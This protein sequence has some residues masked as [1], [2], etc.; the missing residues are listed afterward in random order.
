[1]A[2]LFISD[3]H[4]S[5]ARPGINRIFFE[6]LRGLPARAGDLWIL[7]DL[8]E[9]W[10]GD[11]DADDPFNRG[12]LDAMAQCAR[13]GTRI[14]VMH[15]NRDFLMGPGFEAAS[16]AKLVDDPYTAFIAGRTTL[17]T[18]GDTL[19]TDDREYQAFRAQ[20][21]ARPWQDQ[22]LAQSL[23]E[24]KKQI[25][26]L[27]ERSESE[28]ARKPAE[29]MDVSPRAVESLLR[30]HGYPRLIHGHTHRPARHEH[31]VDGRSCERWVLPDWYETGG[32]LVCDDRGCR[33]ERLA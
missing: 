13:G 24:R 22:F 7:G 30:A 1:M 20:V 28:K 19:C 14:R 2:V 25:E 15:G 11:D 33:M 9:Y 10:A 3:L 26:A 23:A 21:R 18:H 16:G 29:I 27:R 8:F 12:V 6:F 5:Q 17:V 32:V 31:V 4:L